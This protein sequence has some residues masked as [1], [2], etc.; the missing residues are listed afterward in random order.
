LVGE[1]PL[2]DP[3]IAPF[4]APLPPPPKT[5]QAIFTPSKGNPAH[6]VHSKPLELTKLFRESVRYNPNGA[7]TKFL[8]DRSRVLEE[9]QIR[10]QICDQADFRVIPQY[11]Q[12]QRRCA[13]KVVFDY[14][15]VLLGSHKL[16]VAPFKVFKGDRVHIGETESAK[17]PIGW[18]VQAQN[19]QAEG[20]AMLP[21][22]TVERE[23]P[24]KIAVIKVGAEVIH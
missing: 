6:V 7:R 19:P 8:V 10:I 24:G 17:N 2:L 16:L 15:P 5:C 14:A 21:Q 12:R 1:P 9:E 11:E 23:A 13:R 3:V 18:L 4:K 22:G 20:P